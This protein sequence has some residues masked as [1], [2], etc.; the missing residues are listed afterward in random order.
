MD[1]TEIASNTEDQERGREFELLDPV[2]GKAIG[3]TFRVAGPDSMTQRKAELRLV[4]DLAALA[5]EDGRVSAEVREKA[6]IE[7]LARCVL[8]WT[9]EEDGKAIP[10][11]HANVV[12]VLSM[13][14]WIQQQV[15]GF[16]GDRAAFMGDR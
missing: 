9:I 7:C 14:K 4:D 13:A 10:F 3:I 16:A 5:D 12:R 1:L 11:T 2:T 15:D 6:R 8:G